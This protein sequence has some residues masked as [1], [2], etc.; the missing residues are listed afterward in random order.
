M[1]GVAA[2]FCDIS[3]KLRATAY[4][5][6]EFSPPDTAIGQIGTENLPL[7]KRPRLACALQ[8]R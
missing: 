4:N 1:P 5:A 2:R 8:N 7:L 3:T 6:G